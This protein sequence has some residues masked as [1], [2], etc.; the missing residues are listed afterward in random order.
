MATTIMLMLIIT[1]IL[2][3]VEE[4]KTGF[5]SRL[6]VGEMSRPLFV[7]I[8]I[9]VYTFC[10]TT[11]ILSARDGQLATPFAWVFATAMFLNGLGHVALMVARRRYFPGG[12]TAALLLILSGYL[13][14]HLWGA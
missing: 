1:L 13:M 8:N 5:R 9:V 10:F 6:P 2:H 4:F 12:V 7:G 14:L 11:L 3:L